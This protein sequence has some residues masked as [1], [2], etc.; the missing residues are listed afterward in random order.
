MTLTQALQALEAAG[1]AQNRKVYARHGVGPKQFGVSYAVLGKLTKQIKR[2]HAL[3][4]GL[5]DSGWHDARVLA[6]F[7]ADPQQAD[8][9]TLDEW[10]LG[11]ESRPLAGAVA[12]LV[13]ATASA[14]ALAAKW[15]AD[16]RESVAVTGWDVVAELALCST[17][18]DSKFAAL[19]KTIESEIHQSPNDVRYAMN[20][21][22]IAIGVRNPKLEKLAVS[23]AKRIG[24]VEVDHGE[25]GCKTPD[26]VTYIA[27]AV[28]HGRRKAKP[29]TRK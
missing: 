19:L 6:T 16:S 9:A 4:L 22:L 3:A 7:I 15:C 13:A 12:K 17:V 18:D 2:D 29:A 28:A 24:K 20:G 25:T 14:E 21:A 1:T 11:A 10:V 5:W 23:A 26:A 27:K 8:A